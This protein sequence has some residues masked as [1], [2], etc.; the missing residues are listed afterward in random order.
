[1]ASINEI[2]EVSPSQYS[3]FFP[4][5]HYNIPKATINKVKSTIT[6]LNSGIV[7]KT[8][9][10]TASTPY[11]FVI[12][13]NN[14]SIIDLTQCY[15]NIAGRIRLPADTMATSNDISLGN[16]F[17]TSLFQ[18][19]TLEMGGSV[20]AMNANPGI[21][22]NMQAA[23]KFDRA[24]L[25]NY[26]VSD[27][28]FM[29]NYMDKDFEVAQGEITIPI[30]AVMFPA[31][32]NALAGQ[33]YPVTA[34]P[35]ATNLKN[36]RILYNGA[37][38]YPLGADH[39]LSVSAMDITFGAD[40]K[41]VSGWCAVTTTQAQAA[42]FNSDEMVPVQ[43]S[44]KIAALDEL[45]PQKDRCSVIPNC[46][47]SIEVIDG[48]QYVTFPFRCKLFLSDLF[49]YTVDSLDYIFD[50]EI[51]I[52]L[53]RSASSHIIANI[54]S[55]LSSSTTRADV[56]EMNK[57]E[58]VCFTY[59]LT[60]KAR[61]QLIQHYSQPV[62]TLYG[63]QTTN[64]T[65]LYQFS[66][67]T[68]QTITL[69]LTVNFDTKAIILAFPKCANAMVPL[70]TPLS[71]IIVDPGDVGAGDI[72]AGN[73]VRYQTS[74][75]NSN[76]NSYN[77]CG[78]RYIRI[79]NTSNSNIYTYDFQGTEE[80]VQNPSLFLKSFDHANVGAG[81]QCKILDYRDAYNQFKQLRMLFGKNIDNCI[82]YYEYLKDYCLIVC[83]LTGTNIPPNTRLMVTMQFSDYGDNYSPMCFGNVKTPQDGNLLTTNLLAIF[84]GS[85]V[86]SYNPDRTVTVKHVLSANPNEKNTT[87]M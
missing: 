65:P 76:A 35:T 64:L 60:D 20:I 53:T 18:N 57:F 61:T 12:G 49:N 22:A 5:Q 70:N 51:K 30:G 29:I 84:L 87:L 75:L 42:Q 21:D 24:D 19:A 8:F 74:W 14:M 73:K 16:L 56:Y 69:P 11:D 3:Q 32:P 2:S 23:L 33:I 58:L 25:E 68:E 81:L 86:L 7:T 13:A 26:V 85:D 77:F 10:Q 72:A 55:Y 78:L 83:D 67:Q 54:T 44:T 63:V 39:S 41:L 1:M 66:S 36:I 43:A 9:S 82:D 62:E 38:L 52:T 4:K 79:F 47:P 80:T 31:L 71:H 40:G 17:I 27:R 59:L 37:A 45:I 48:N 46:K 50:R 28:E 15:F 34:G 6:S